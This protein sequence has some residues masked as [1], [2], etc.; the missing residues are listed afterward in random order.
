[1]NFSYLFLTLSHTIP[2]LHLSEASECAWALYEHSCALPFL[3][4]YF[5]TQQHIYESP[6]L[7]EWGLIR[8]TSMP[9]YRFLLLPHKIHLGYFWLRIYMIL[10]ARTSRTIIPIHGPSF[11]CCL[12]SI[13]SQTTLAAAARGVWGK[14]ARPSI[15]PWVRRDGSCVGCLTVGWKPSLFILPPFRDVCVSQQQFICVPQA[16]AF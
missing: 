8:C 7:L 6:L 9:L 5:L 4:L 10:W 13:R 12:V 3:C 16:Q 1:M 2:P 11:V 14:F 15:C